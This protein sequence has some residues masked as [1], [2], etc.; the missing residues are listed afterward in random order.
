MLTEVRGI[1]N[2]TCN[3]ILDSMHKSGANFEDALAE[4]Q[5]LGYAEKDPTS[6][7]EGTDTLRKCVISTNLAFDANVTEDQ[8]PAC[9]ISSIS[10]EDIQFFNSNGYTC[11]LMMYSKV[12]DGKLSAY[13]EPAIF[14][15]QH[16]EANVKANNNLIT[17]VGENVGTL[18]FFGQGAGSAPTG[19]SVIQDV[20][21]IKDGVE[22]NSPFHD[23]FPAPV[24]EPAVE[25]VEEEQAE[26][27]FIDNESQLHTY[28]FRHDHPSR[29]ITEI[30]DKF[31]VVDGTY[32]CISKPIPV[33]EMHE[34]AKH[35]KQ[36]E[37]PFF[38]AHMHE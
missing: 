11:K 7:I 35:M 8:I 32:Y 9:G 10:A 24:E 28:Y 2:G 6:D 26:T 16:L 25:A 21:D 37:S 31:A 38:F 27:S 17:L 34:L 29:M 36:V 12:M 19:Q 23:Y 5:K 18:S 22:M 30:T 3:Y 20:I 13:V 15:P 4:A 33:V 14:G 1:V